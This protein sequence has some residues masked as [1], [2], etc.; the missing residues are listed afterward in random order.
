[1][2]CSHRFW[3]LRLHDDPLG[4]SEMQM[5]LSEM[6]NYTKHYEMPN[7]TNY[8][9]ANSKKCHILLSAVDRKRG[10]IFRKAGHIKNVKFVLGICIYLHMFHECL[11]L[12]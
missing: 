4:G 12:N 1:M 9:R 5:L 2:E 11:G 3:F 10:M 7:Y 6:P 8:S